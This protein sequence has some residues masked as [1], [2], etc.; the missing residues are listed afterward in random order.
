M[1]NSE[2]S[3]ENAPEQA[4]KGTQLM[5]QWESVQRPSHFELSLLEKRS[6]QRKFKKASSDRYIVRLSK[7]W[8]NVSGKG[9]STSKLG[10]QVPE[11]C[12]E[13]WVLNQTN[14]QGIQAFKRFASIHMPQ[15]IV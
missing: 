1:E 4:G 10:P 5:C 12:Q 14:T 3:Q 11:W 6:F 8:G 15:D 13:A 7:K 2:H 9:P